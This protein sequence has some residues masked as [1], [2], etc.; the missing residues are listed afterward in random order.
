[1]KIF[2][3]VGLFNTKLAGSDG[4]MAAEWRKF[5]SAFFS[6]TS[7]QAHTI[8]LAKITGAGVNGSITFNENGVV[9]GYVDPT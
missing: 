2:P 5:W 8:P 9:T 6:Q 4:T 3:S 1:M 7:V